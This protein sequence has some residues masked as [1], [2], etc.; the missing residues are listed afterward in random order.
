MCYVQ[1][2]HTCQCLGNIEPTYT[3]KDVRSCLCPTIVR[4]HGLR[5]KC[6]PCRRQQKRHG[7]KKSPEQTDLNGGPT[8]S[9]ETMGKAG[10]VEERRFADSLLNY[11]HVYPSG[12][13]RTRDCTYHGRAFEV[14]GKEDG[15]R[16]NN[17]GFD[18][19]TSSSW[20]TG[21]PHGTPRMGR[22]VFAAEADIVDVCQSSDGQVLGGQFKQQIID[23]IELLLGQLM[24]L[25]LAGLVFQTRT[26]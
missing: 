20:N 17:L 2:V 7:K 8:S 19:L 15:R 3:P 14:S 9:S 25:N 23:Q 21:R 6:G 5:N 24:G 10:G 18:I 4:M 11:W 12:G 22:L 16:P 13:R 26:I 1:N